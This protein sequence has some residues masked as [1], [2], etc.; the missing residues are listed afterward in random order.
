M[1]VI[2]LIHICILFLCILLYVLAFCYMY[3]V[4]FFL[5]VSLCI[6]HISLCKKYT[7]L[8]KNVKLLRIKILINAASERETPNV[9]KCGSIFTYFQKMYA[10]CFITC[11]FLP[12]HLCISVQVERALGYL[13]PI[14]GCIELNLMSPCTKTTALD[15]TMALRSSPS[16]EYL[17]NGHLG[18]F[19]VFLYH[20]LFCR[21]HP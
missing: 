15:C 18:F 10:C 1:Y 13:T 3:G 8:R 11:F 6:I 9:I 19:K 21:N 12:Q 14:S 20:K 16:I 7:L 2:L 17:T 5:Y 4:S